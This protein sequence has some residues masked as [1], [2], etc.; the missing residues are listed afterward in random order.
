L[1]DT[2]HVEEFTDAERARLAPYFSYTD[3]NVFAL[4]NV[5]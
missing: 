2:L 5:P 1:L 3:R 4:K